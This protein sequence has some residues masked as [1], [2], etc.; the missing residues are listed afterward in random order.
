MLAKLL[1]QTD[2]KDYDDFSRNF[3][4]MRPDNFNFAFDC[5]DALAA[6]SPDRTAMVWYSDDGREAVY[7]FA[8]MSA[9]SDAAARFFASF[10]IGRGD[11]VMLI[12]RRRAQFWI[13]ILG[14]MKLG[15]VSIP[16]THLLTADDVAYRNN[17]ASVAAILCTEEDS[18]V[19]TVDAAMDR[20]PTVRLR[21][22][23]GGPRPGWQ[24]FDAGLDEFAQGP[25]PARLTENG[26]MMLLYFTSGTTGM[27]K[28]VAHNFIYPLGHISTARYWHRLHPDSLH[29][30]LAD[31]G[32]A[33]AAWGKIYGQWL[34]GAAIFAY[35]HSF[36]DVHRFLL[37]ISRHRVTS[38]CAPPTVFRILANSDL[39]K[40]DLGALEH[41]SSA[42]EPLSEEL[43]SRF[44]DMTGLS[45]HEAYGQTETTPLIMN[46]QYAKPRP[47]SLGRPNPNYRLAFL[48]DDG[49]EVPPG[50]EGE[51]CVRSKPG[52][53]GMF[54]GYYR[55]EGLTAHAWRGGVYHTGDVAWQDSDGY[56]WFIGR[57]DDIIKSAGYRIGPFEIESVLL[58]HPAVLECAVTGV[59]DS[60]RGQAIKASVVLR[61]GYEPSDGLKGELRRHVRAMTS[62]YKTPR[63]IEF[64]DD[65]PKTV[66]GKIQRAGRRPSPPAA[67]R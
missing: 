45:I 26:D 25:P 62:A 51:I 18:I 35:D 38:L 42:G 3:Q 41:V 10:G 7:S 65:L 30:T 33:K 32:W 50:G 56:I 5:I 40:Y 55:D 39:S 27:P 66:S 58:K 29:L 6:S 37:A 63:Q 11:P 17:A 28:M 46:T 60:L 19:G 20:S 34:C 47:G 4:V 21:V 54:M 64:V 44:R 22:K 31:T 14:L 2:F 53:M 36:F 9:L 12:L 43:F 61:E 16:A 24:S 1:K 52:E 49:N 15:A 23:L 57:V 48:D 8:M 13:A 67:D 59:P